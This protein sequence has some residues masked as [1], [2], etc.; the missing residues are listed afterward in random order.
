MRARENVVHETGLFHAKLGLDRTIIIRE[1]GCQDFSNIHG[2]VEVRYARD[3]IRESFGE[4]VATIRR[5]FP[6]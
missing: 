2:I 3:N 6:A 1:E 4:V 5:E